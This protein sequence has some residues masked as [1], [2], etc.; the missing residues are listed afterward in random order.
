MHL[1]PACIL[2]LRRILVWTCHISD[3][4]FLDRTGATTSPPTSPAPAIPMACESSSHLSHSSDNTESLTARPPEN[5][6]PFKTEIQLIYS[7]LFISSVQQSDSVTHIHV[8]ICVYMYNI[9]FHIL[10]HYGKTQGLFSLVFWICFRAASVHME[11]P[12]T[13]VELE[14]SCWPTS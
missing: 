14:L 10:F 12:R 8:Y 3:A 4:A 11:V 13:G 6:A 5:S 7:V 1:N 9:L 2:Y